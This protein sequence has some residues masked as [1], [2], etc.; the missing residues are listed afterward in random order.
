M[1]SPWWLTGGRE[2]T[3]WS[4]SWTSSPRLILLEQSSSSLL[5][6]PSSPTKALQEEPLENPNGHS[7]RNSFKTSAVGRGEKAS[8]QTLIS[9]PQPATVKSKTFA[10][11]S[12]QQSRLAMPFPSTGTIRGFMLSH[13][14][15]KCLN[16]SERSLHQ[17]A[18]QCCSSQNSTGRPQHG[19]SF[20]V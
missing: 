7:E 8:C 17:K 1:V 3:P 16:A 5:L 10:L 14:G 15:R 13:R 2:Q 12:S 18:L 19:Q 6:Q 20:L 9:L 11:D 4:H